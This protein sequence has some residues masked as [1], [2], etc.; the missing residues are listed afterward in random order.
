MQ[1]AGKPENLE[2]LQDGEETVLTGAEGGM[3]SKWS[4]RHW[5][6]LKG[7]GSMVENLSLGA[8]ET[9]EL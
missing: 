9:R 6:D 3:E 4:A 7:P 5:P 1:R 8:V 2:C